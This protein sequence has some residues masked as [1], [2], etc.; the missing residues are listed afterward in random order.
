[1]FGNNSIIN[2][3]ESHARVISSCC[4]LLLGEE[5]RA[6]FLIRIYG[7]TLAII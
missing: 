2:F 6:Y 5:R 3:S 7:L 4:R 1:M